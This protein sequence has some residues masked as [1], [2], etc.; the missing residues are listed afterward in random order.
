MTSIICVIIVGIVVVA[1]IIRNR[2]IG[3]DMVARSDQIVPAIR[4]STIVGQGTGHDMTDDG[5][6]MLNAIL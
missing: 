5:T 2:R 3:R 4:P 6:I 1:V